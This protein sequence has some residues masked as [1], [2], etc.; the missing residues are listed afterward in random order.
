ML[1]NLTAALKARNM[2]NDTVFIVL[3]DNGGPS[4][5]AAYNDE[6]IGMKFSHWYV[7]LS[8]DL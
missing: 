6:H 5:D 8:I 3:G 2:Y 4:S 7:Y 1:F